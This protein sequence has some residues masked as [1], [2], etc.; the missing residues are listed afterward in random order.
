MCLTGPNRRRKPYLPC[1]SLQGNPGGEATVTKASRSHAYT[2]SSPPAT[3]RPLGRCR[4]RRPP[5]PHP[6]T[7]TSF[8]RR[9][10]P[11]SLFLFHIQNSSTRCLVSQPCCSLR[12]R[13]PAVVVG[14]GSASY[15]APP[16]LRSR[17]SWSLP[18]ACCFRLLAR[19]C[20]GDGPDGL[21]PAMSCGGLRLRVSPVA[22]FTFPVLV[23]SA[24]TEGLCV[25]RQWM[26]SV[27]STVESLGVCCRCGRLSDNAAVFA[28]VCSI[29]FSS[30]LPGGWKHFE[31][32]HDQL[33]P[34]LH[35]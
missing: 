33:S 13:Q 9:L 14:G 22:R 7:T 2:A 8:H 34:K 5:S 16:P 19:L 27:C 30:C 23:G 28:N 25:G 21:L 1:R 26:N 24:A 20:G 6:N 11:F 4:R 31:P 15:H 10:L 29:P 32:C 17:R 35:V 12:R 18:T 3:L